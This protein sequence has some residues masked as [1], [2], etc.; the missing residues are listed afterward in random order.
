[1]SRLAEAFGILGVKSWDL[2]INPCVSPHFPLLAHLR[3]SIL[4]AKPNFQIITQL[5][6]GSFAHLV[7]LIVWL[8]GAMWSSGIWVFVLLLPNNHWPLRVVSIHYS[9]IQYFINYFS[10]NWNGVPL[11]PFNYFINM[12]FFS[13]FLSKFFSS[14]SLGMEGIIFYGSWLLTFAFHRLGYG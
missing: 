11:I 2:S 14:Y 7:Y 8:N 9:P 6:D 3:G 12:E 13:L 10:I 4:W 1:M 5:L